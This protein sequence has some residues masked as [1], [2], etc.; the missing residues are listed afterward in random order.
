MRGMFDDGYSILV[1]KPQVDYSALRENLIDS[2]NDKVGQRIQA[3]YEEGSAAGNVG[4]CYENRDGGHSK[5]PLHR[6][7]QFANITYDSSL[8]KQKANFGVK[9]NIAND[10]PSIINASLAM[11]EK[12]ASRSMARLILHNAEF[13]SQLY[14][15]YRLS[16]FIFYPEHKDYDQA[17]CFAVNTPYLIISQGSSGSDRPFMFAVAQTLAS[18]HPAVKERLHQ[19]GL[20]AP[21]VQM[22]MRWNYQGIGNAD[23]YLT[24]NAHPTAFD[25]KKLDRSGMANMAHAMTSDCLPPLAMIQMVSEQSSVSG[26]DNFDAGASEHLLDT[27][28]AIGRI[29]RDLAETRTFQVSA[30]ESFDVHGRPLTFHWRVL[31][32][33]T[34]KI[35]IT[36]LNDAGSR[37]E[38]SIRYQ[39]NVTAPDQPDLRTHRVDIGVFVDNGFYYS[40]PAFISIYYPPNEERVYDEHGT[41]QS[42]RYLSPL[43]MPGEADMLLI[44][45]KP[46]TDDYH[47]ENGQLTGWTRTMHDGESSEFDA[48]GQLFESGWF[49]D[50]TPNPATYTTSRTSVGLQTV[51][52]E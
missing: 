41:L 12:P 19:R 9:V 48:S 30:E 29:A 8:K 49:S 44:Y 35:T 34:S 24:G 28:C 37:A 43:D 7:Q 20:L 51:Q 5:L 31:R 4:D 36:P 21:T 42:V 22:I 25:G 47:Y 33:D 52:F 27:P 38:I 14:S 16:D 2:S 17:D 32:G 6:F 40:A 26:V 13:S 11:M 3:W 10:R 1:S 15:F 23:N 39:P 50:S 45:N 46:W 18:F